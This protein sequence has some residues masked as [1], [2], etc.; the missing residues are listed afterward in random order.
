MIDLLVDLLWAFVEHL[1]WRFSK[2]DKARP[3]DF[4]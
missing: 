4:A 3:G 1:C 2:K